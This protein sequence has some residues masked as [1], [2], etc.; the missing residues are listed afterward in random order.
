M[1][2]ITRILIVLGLAGC[3][4]ERG[5]STPDL[6]G[7]WVLSHARSSLEIAAPDSSIF[8]IDHVGP[9]LAARRTH[10][11]DGVV[12][13]VETSLTAD[14]VLRTVRVGEL[15]IPTRV[16][17]DGAVLVLDQAWSQGGVD[18]T[19]LVRYTL[20]D[21]GETLIADESMRAGPSGHHNVWTFE[22]R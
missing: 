16:Y 11:L 14:S 3:T 9:T 22:R 7:T 1:T 12:N 21:G 6:S 10:V 13:V 20:V 2:P 15:E 18:V 8:V 4:V 5:A 17:W 19:N